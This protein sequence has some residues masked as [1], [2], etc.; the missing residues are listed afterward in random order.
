MKVRT[1][2]KNDYKNIALLEQKVWGDGAASYDTIRTRHEIF[3][4]GSIVVV[5][6]NE[7]I[8]GYGAAQRV[9]RICCD[10]W[11]IQTGNGKTKSTHRKNG[12]ILY[13]IGMAGASF[14][15]AEMILDYAHKTFIAS[16]ICYMMMLGSR[17]PGFAKWQEKNKL[18]IK[19]YIQARRK[20]GYSID[21]ELML[22]QKNGFEILC[23][24]DGYFP[25]QDSLNYGAL[26][27]K[28]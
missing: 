27:I 14:G 17:V 22:Y 1:A 16:G 10:S 2:T 13:G 15:V 21:P 23:E 7:T 26:I 19:E 18:G 12:H 3:P 25:C 20:D 6:Q 9:D 8:V 5:D 28:R 11:Q 24:I 4:S